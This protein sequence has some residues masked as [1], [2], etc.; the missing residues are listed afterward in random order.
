MGVFGCKPWLSTPALR[1]AQ[2]MQA[3]MP[4]SAM[5]FAYQDLR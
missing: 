4:C 3:S 2:L 5:V 1:E